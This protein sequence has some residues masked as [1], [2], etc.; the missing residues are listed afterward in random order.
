MPEE[1]FP[2]AHGLFA[3]EREG[4][5]VC[6]FFLMNLPTA[7]CKNQPSKPQRNLRGSLPTKK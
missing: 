2:S 6:L 3:G 5:G 4:L 7:I 1:D